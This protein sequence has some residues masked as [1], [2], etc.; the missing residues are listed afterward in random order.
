L[1]ATRQD[2]LAAGWAEEKVEAMNRKERRRLIVARPSRSKTGSPAHFAAWK[3]EG[4]IKSI[5]QKMSTAAL[6]DSLEGPISGAFA[7]LSVGGFK[8]VW[9]VAQSDLTALLAVRGIGPGRLHEI[10]AYLKS[11]NVP[12]NWTAA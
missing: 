3:A 11:R 2:L 5:L 10:E 12:L 8:N 6:A 1:R 9:A 4:R 7:L